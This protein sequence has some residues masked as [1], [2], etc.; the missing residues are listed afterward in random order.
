[1]TRYITVGELT[2]ND[3]GKYVSIGGDGDFAEGPLVDFP[4]VHEWV[5]D[6]SLCDPEDVIVPRAVGANLTVGRW[7][8][9]F[10]PL[11]TPITIHDN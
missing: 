2:L 1:M 10:V 5:S 6:R 4:I 7:T 11:H 3:L 8:R 9:E